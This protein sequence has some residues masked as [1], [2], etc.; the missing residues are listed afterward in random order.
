MASLLGAIVGSV[1]LGSLL[2]LLVQRFIN[3]DLLSPA[4][5]ATRVVIPVTAFMVLL[6]AWGGGRGGSLDLWFGL[7]YI[8]GGFLLWLL[9]RRE[10]QR[11]L[12]RM[13]DTDTFA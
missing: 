6:G 10:Y 3:S 11:T 9:K 5:R 1:L 4:E 2:C 13:R 7:Q 8:P 12:D